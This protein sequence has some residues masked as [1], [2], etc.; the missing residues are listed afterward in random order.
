MKFRVGDRV[1]DRLGLK[2]IIVAVGENTSCV[3]NHDKKPTWHNNSDLSLE[4]TRCFTRIYTDVLEEVVEHNINYDLK[5]NP[6]YYISN[7]LSV[8]DIGVVV[9]YQKY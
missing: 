1:V 3:S 8:E 6:E 7:I 4:D 5:H 9:V 2:G